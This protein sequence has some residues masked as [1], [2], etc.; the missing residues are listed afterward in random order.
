M[1]LKTVNIK[2]KEYVMVNER[3]KDF[4]ET[5]KNGS[6]VTELISD[7][8]EARVIFKATAY[9]DVTDINRKFTGYSQAIWGEGMVNK[10]SALEN[11]ET[12]AV[13]R[14]LGFM[15]IGVIDSIASVDEINKAETMQK[16]DDEGLYAEKFMNKINLDMEKHGFSYADALAGMKQYGF[17]FTGGVQALK[18][19]QVVEASKAY[20]KW[21][22]VK[23]YEVSN[24][25]RHKVNA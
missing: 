16:Y 21:L 7:N 15:G 10:T 25:Y 13:G 23:G 5:Y 19:Y 2:G 24:D 17:A 3:V 11:A 20:G 14:A 4:N 18:N 6:I 1:T 12:S 8:A 22:N 9:P